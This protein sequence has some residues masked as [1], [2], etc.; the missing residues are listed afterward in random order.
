MS[1]TPLL[2]RQATQVPVIRGAK[3][4]VVLVDEHG[5]VSGIPFE[6]PSVSDRELK[7]VALRAGFSLLHAG[8]GSPPLRNV[9]GRSS[10]DQAKV[11]RRKR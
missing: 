5:R 1:R 10:S 9:R 11:G 8:P 6:L 2:N 7:K 3:G 4:G